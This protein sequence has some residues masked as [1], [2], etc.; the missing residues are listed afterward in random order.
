ML[1]D[2]F[3][4]PSELNPDQ[5]IS[6]RAPVEEGTAFGTADFGHAVHE[7]LLQHRCAGGRFIVVHQAILVADSSVQTVRR[8]AEP[9]AWCQPQYLPERETVAFGVKAPAELQLHWSMIVQSL[10][11]GLAYFTDIDA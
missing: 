5:S 9:T 1:T 8:T 3:S 11:M 2:A 10:H 6:L 4:S 7:G